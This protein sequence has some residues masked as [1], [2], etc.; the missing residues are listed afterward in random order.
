MVV[1]K[2]VNSRYVVEN[3]LIGCGGS[4]V[5]NE[6]D[7]RYK[8]YKESTL[9]KGIRFR[10]R[11]RIT[12]LRFRTLFKRFC[13]TDKRFPNTVKSNS[14]NSNQQTLADSGA[15]ERPPM[16]E[17]G[18]YIPWESRFRRFLDNKLEDGERMWNS[19]QNG[20]YQRPMVVDPTNPT[21]P[22]LEPLSKMTEGN[23]KQY[24]ADVRVMNYLLQA[25]PNDIYN[26]VDAC[27]NAKEMWEQIKRL[28]HGSEITTHVRHSRLMDEFDKFAAKEGESLDSVHERLTTLV[29]IMDCNNLVQ[30]EPHVLASGAKKAVKNHDP[31]AL[32]T[33]LNAFSSHSYANSFYSLQPYYVTHPP[34][35]VDYD[36]EYQ[37]EL[38]GN[39]QEDNLTTAMINKTQGFNTGDE[40]NQIIQHVPQTESTP[41]KANVQYYNCNE[42]D[43]YARECQKLRVHDSKYFR[44][45]MLLAMKDEVGSN[46]NIEENDFMLDT[47][48]GEDLEEFTAVVMLM[49]RLQPTDENAETVP[50]YDAKAVS[51]L[52]LGYYKIPW[53]HKKAIA[54]QPKSVG[55]SNSVRRP[56]SKDNKSKNNVLK[57]TKSSSTYVLK[58]TNSVCLDSNKCETK[59]SNVCQTNACRTSSKTVNAVNDG[60]NMLCISCGLDVF[61]HS[62]EKCVARNALTRKSSVKRALFTSPVTAKS[63]GLGATS[64]VAKSRFSVAKTPTATTKVSSVSPPS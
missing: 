37:G 20:P 45:Q 1:R 28:M 13:N 32:I 54:A 41:G 57:N 9:C 2:K 31:L 64:V 29:N 12:S 24:I 18:N 51:Q 33:H 49:A 44:E 22:I 26:S 35:V 62:H 46:L 48:Y 43:H 4:Y 53:C 5:G 63:K 38:Q 55:S 3:V 58:T 59:P 10:K 19:I 36:D 40:S 21:V 42:K 11:F 60:L 52:G 34:S 16:L 56:K 8:K 7:K 61:L 17:K 47:S 39:S 27:K 23:K 15:N 50:S 6:G 25:I 30:F 14:T